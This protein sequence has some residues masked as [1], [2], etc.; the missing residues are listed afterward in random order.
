VGTVAE[1]AV[2]LLLVDEAVV[3]VFEPAP[4]PASMRAKSSAW[5]FPAAGGA[6]VV[7]EVPELEL[8][9]GGFGVLDVEAAA[10]GVNL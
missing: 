3:L 5:L 7:P 10:G 4:S 8:A 9:A 2:E 6:V 1:G